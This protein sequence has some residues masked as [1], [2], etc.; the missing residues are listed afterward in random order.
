VWILVIISCA[1]FVVDT[2]TAVKLLAFNQWSSQIEPKIPFEVTKW[3][4]SSCILFSW[5]I[6]IY[7]WIRAYRVMQ[8]ES[9]TE[10]YLDPLAVVLQSIRFDGG[11]RRF[12]VFAKLTKSKKKATWFALFVYFER[13]GK[14]CTKPL[15]GRLR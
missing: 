9:V 14:S 8:R 2:F 11:Y 12:Q 4:F 10:D 7:E 1:V 15:W 3:I 13:K 5:L 6:C